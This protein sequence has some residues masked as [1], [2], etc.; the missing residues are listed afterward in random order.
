M[1]AASARSLENYEF[2]GEWQMKCAKCGQEFTGNF[3]PRCGAAVPKAF[4]GVVTKGNFVL[5]WQHILMGVGAL[6]FLG[7]VFLIVIILL[8]GEIRDESS[9]TLTMSMVSGEQSRSQST[10]E[11]NLESSLDESS[12]EDAST[13]KLRGRGESD[14]GRDEPQYVNCSGYVAVYNVRGKEFSE[15]PWMIP[16]YQ[17]DKQFYVEAGTVEHKTAV[18]V[19]SQELEHTGWGNYSGHLIVERNDTHEQLCIN[20]KNFII[21]PYWEQENESLLEIAMTGNYLAEFNQIS[22]Y[23]PVDNQG[24]KVTLEDGVTVLVTGKSST[25]G[26]SSKENTIDGIAFVEQGGTLQEVSACFHPDDLTLVY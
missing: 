10:T 19:L 1:C 9:S 2:K 26:R 24:K 15:T 12:Q 7:V 16:T 3:C 11:S 13:G 21:D 5:K 4:L 22:D 20:V 8:F 14:N 17:K 18:T 23:Y 6:A 25:L